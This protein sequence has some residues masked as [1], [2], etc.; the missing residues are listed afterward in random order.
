MAV[1]SQEGSDGVGS[2]DKGGLVPVRERGR[3]ESREVLSAGNRR[4]SATSI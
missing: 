2:Q 1:P 3:G 4:S